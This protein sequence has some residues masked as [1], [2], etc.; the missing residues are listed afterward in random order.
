MA[1]AGTPSTVNSWPA[2]G[3]P[4]DLAWQRLMPSEWGAYAQARDAA[5]GVEQ[6]LLLSKP[7]SVPD[8]DQRRLDALKEARTA[9]DACLCVFLERGEFELWGRRD[10][11]LAQ[12]ENV[13]VTALSYLCIDIEQRTAAM[14]ELKLFDL[15]L[16]QPGAPAAK[17][18]HG[19][20]MGRVQLALKKRY[21]PDGRAPG[22][23]TKAVRK[24][25]V[26]DLAEDSKQR[27]L[28]APSWD[29]VNRALGR[30]K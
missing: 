20:Q 11:P 25:I 27:G 9:V 23:S 13:S 18:R 8:N 29:T 14:E 22:I 12:A 26:E 5:R 19:P 6:M 24:L 1:K 10:T 30:A 3:V 7:I 17:T 16:R 4:I 15:R 2:E 21:P 28:A